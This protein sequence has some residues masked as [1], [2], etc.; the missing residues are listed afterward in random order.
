[1]INSCI[2]LFAQTIKGANEWQQFKKLLLVACLFLLKISA[3]HDI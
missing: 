1:M 2:E 3:R